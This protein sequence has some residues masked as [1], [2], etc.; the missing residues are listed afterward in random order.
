MIPFEDNKTCDF[1]I[2]SNDTQEVII[3]KKNEELFRE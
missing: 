3:D 1:E 2:E